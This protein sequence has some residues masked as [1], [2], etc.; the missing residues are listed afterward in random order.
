MRQTEPDPRLIGLFEKHYAEVL[1]YCVRRIGPDEA[2][3]VAAEVFA[4]AWRRL[5]DIRMESARAWL[6]GTA[7]GVISN[8]WRSL[9]SR[10][11]LSKR[12]AGLAPDP[13]ETPDVFIVRREEDEE[14]VETLKTLK[15]SDQ[16]ILMLSAWE[17][18]SNAEIAEVLDITKSAAEQ[19]LH[20][21]KQRFAKVLEP[22]PPKISPRAAEERGGSR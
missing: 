19:R 15:D 7:R 5:D 13:Q 14:V 22:S 1:A 11:R 2:E 18:L 16:E 4:I 8:R 21:A 20:R 9:K 12:I 17:E 10:S 3:D 6:Y